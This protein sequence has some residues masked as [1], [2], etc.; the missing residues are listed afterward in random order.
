MTLDIH[1]KLTAVKNSKRADQCHMPTSRA[2][3]LSLRMFIRRRSSARWRPKKNR[4]T[5]ACSLHLCN[6]DIG[7]PFH[8]Q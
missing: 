4:S 2:Q 5:Y 6:L 1:V 3:M 7:D 8:D